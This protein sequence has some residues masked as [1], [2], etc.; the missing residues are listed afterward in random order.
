MNA[1]FVETSIQL[2]VLSDSYYV[3]S[4]THTSGSGFQHL[5]TKNTW[6]QYDNLNNLII[7]S[8]NATILRKQ[9]LHPTKWSIF[10]SPTSSSISQITGIS[11]Q[12]KILRIILEGHIFRKT[13][14]SHSL[15]NQEQV[16]GAILCLRVHLQCLARNQIHQKLQSI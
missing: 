2:N 14:D 5:Q 8:E 6:K 12:L 9:F 7:F 16:T 3:L 15:V 13:F 4:V 10:C 1:L 11:I